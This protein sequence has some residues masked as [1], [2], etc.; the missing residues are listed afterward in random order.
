MIYAIAAVVWVALGYAAL[1]WNSY[2]EEKPF[3][4]TEYTYGTDDKFP[5]VFVVLLGGGSLFW[6]ITKRVQ[7][8]ARTA[9]REKR[10]IAEELEKELVAARREIDAMLKRERAK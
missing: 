7:I 5:L 10:L 4:V 8:A 2:V 6:V 3:V 1:I 9:G